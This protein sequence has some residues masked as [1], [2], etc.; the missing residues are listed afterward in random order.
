[1]LAEQLEG[2]DNRKISILSIY[3]MREQF[4]GLSNSKSERQIN[5]LQKKVGT[6]Y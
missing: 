3:L 1:V 5:S 6:H 2:K 4:I